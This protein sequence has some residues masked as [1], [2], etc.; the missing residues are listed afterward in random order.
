MPLS[1]EIICAY[2]CVKHGTFDTMLLYTVI[3]WF[4]QK[5]II[6]FFFKYSSGTGPWLVKFFDLLFQRK[7]IN[8]IK[9]KESCIIVT[10]NAQI[11]FYEWILKSTTN[12]QQ[13]ESLSLIFLIGMLNFFKHLLI[14]CLPLVLEIALA[15]TT[16]KRS[17]N[18]ICMPELRPFIIS[19][20][21]ECQ[22]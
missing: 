13:K 21:S 19:V 11:S 14:Q 1:C 20:I 4:S 17:L 10:R 18:V 3:Q 8:F 7:E 12:P 2:L 22:V 6:A 5:K 15:T 9:L 16:K